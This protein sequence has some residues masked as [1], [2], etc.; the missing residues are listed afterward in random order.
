MGSR[1]FPTESP[2]IGGV[3]S[4]PGSLEK[5]PAQAGQSN[6][7]RVLTAC[8]SHMSG[9]AAPCKQTPSV[10]PSEASGGGPQRFLGFS[11]LVFIEGPPGFRQ[12]GTL[13]LGVHGCLCTAGG[14]LGQGLALTEGFWGPLPVHCPQRLS[15][16]Y[17]GTSLFSTLPEAGNVCSS[18][19]VMPA[20]P[21]SG[22]CRWF[23]ASLL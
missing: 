12:Q 2:R 23:P 4:F 18:P 14:A 19:H 5:V 22:T 16:V 7:G 15:P 3:S 8:L 10:S 20:C 9:S 1:P 21:I 11:A 6:V 13:P 17:L